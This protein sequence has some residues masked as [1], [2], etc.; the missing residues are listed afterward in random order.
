[1]SDKEELPNAVPCGGVLATHGVFMAACGIYGAYLHNFEKKVMHSAYAGVGGMVALSL[2]AA[3]TVSGSNKLY[4]I[5]VHA[6][7]LLQS[8]FVGTFA[9]QAYRSYGIPEK[10]DRHRLFVVM[11]VGSGILLAAMLALKPKKQ[12]KRQK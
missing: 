4:M 12:D 6:G 5:G 11:G 1:M 9:K 10:A 7:L 3:M 2:S 8:L